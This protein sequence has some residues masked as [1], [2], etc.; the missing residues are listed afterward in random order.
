MFHFFRMKD[1]VSI[2]LSLE[3]STSV[4]PHRIETVNLFKKYIKIYRSTDGPQFKM[5]QLEIFQFHDGTKGIRI[6]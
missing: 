5:V 2:F 1:F 6:Q 4:A 3:T